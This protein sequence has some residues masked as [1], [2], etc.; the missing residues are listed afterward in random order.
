MYFLQPK[1]LVRRHAQHTCNMHTY[2][3]IHTYIQHS[4][5]HIH[6][7]YMQI[8][9]VQTRAQICICG[10][11]SDVCAC[12]S[13][14]VCYMCR[15]Q[16]QSILHVLY[17]C[18]YM[19]AACVCIDFNPYVHVLYVSY[20]CACMLPILYVLTQARANA[21]TTG[22]KHPLAGRQ[23]ADPTQDNPGQQLCHFIQRSGTHSQTRFGAPVRAARVGGGAKQPS[24]S[25]HGPS[26]SHGHFASPS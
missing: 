4:Y 17:V 20:V 6:T 18:V 11:L 2:I 8:H 15:N 23:P 13:A 26:T 10:L 9:A 21:V 1:L 24:C 19:Y 14:Y 12:M 22:P 7:K 3:H 16:I 5:I 25:A